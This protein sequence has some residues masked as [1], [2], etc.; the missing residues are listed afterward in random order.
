MLTTKQISLDDFKKLNPEMRYL[1]LLE[2]CPDLFQR[3]PLY[4]IAWY[5]GIKPEFLSWMRKRL[6]TKSE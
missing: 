2:T 6:I 3:V 1:K 5:L 4:H